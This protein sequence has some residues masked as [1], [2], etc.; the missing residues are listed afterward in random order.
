MYSKDTGKI[1]YCFCFRFGVSSSCVRADPWLLVGFGES[2]EMPEIEL[3]SAVY[4]ANAVSFMLPLW[5]V[6]V[7]MWDKGLG[8]EGERRRL[9]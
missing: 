3:W 7:H 4:K 9:M 1:I 2:Y 8:I 6:E 5:P